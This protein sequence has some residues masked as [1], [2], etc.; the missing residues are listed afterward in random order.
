[1]SENNTFIFQ[2]NVTRDCDLRCTHC[3]ISS[4]KK[5]ASA[6]MS[7]QEFTES[8]FKVADYMDNDWNSARKYSRVEISVV[9]GEPSLMG[10]S[11]FENTMPAIKERF[12]HVNQKVKL[13]IVSNLLQKRAVTIV[14]MFDHITTSYEVDSRFT[15]QKQEDQTFLQW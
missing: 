11:F 6:F 10:V 14:K 8:I 9:G 12:S 7:E 15:K 1:M 2:V 4:D 5:K 13:S 3:Y